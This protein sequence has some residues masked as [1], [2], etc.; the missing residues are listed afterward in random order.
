MASSVLLGSLL[1]I[2]EASV[3]LQVDLSSSVDVVSGWEQVE[4]RP[5]PLQPSWD[6]L[7]QL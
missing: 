7:N 3:G 1:Q 4:E 2:S 5:D 6:P